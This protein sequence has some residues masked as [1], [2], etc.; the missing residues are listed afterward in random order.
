M[1]AHCISDDVELRLLEERHAEELFHLADRNRELLRR[2]LPWIDHTGSAADSLNFIRSA[3][4]QF[5]RNEGFHAGIWWQGTLAG[6]IGTHKIDWPNRQTSLGYWLDA[7]CQGRGIVT[8]ACRAL[9]GHLFGELGMNRVEIRCGV[10]NEK[11]C[12]IAE[13]LGFTREGVIRDAQWVGGRFIDLAVYG[14]LRRQWLGAP[15]LR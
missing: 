10:A 4:Q 8:G 2:W 5:A 14:M 15:M 6:A 12:A 7:S 13:R 9:L 11:S 1:F 3:V